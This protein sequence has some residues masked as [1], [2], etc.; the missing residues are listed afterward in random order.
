MYI[1]IPFCR[2]ACSYC[3]FHFS[4]SFFYLDDMIEAIINE[5]AQRKNYLEGA[6]LETIYFGGGTPSVLNKNHLAR[7]MEAIFSNYKISLSREITLEANPDDLTSEYLSDIVRLGFNRLSIGVQSFYQD[8]LKLMNRTHDSE[9]AKR[10]IHASRDAGL[11]NLNVDLI[12]GFPGLTMKKWDYNICKIIELDVEHLSAY[13]ITYEPGTRLYYLKR[14]SKLQEAKESASI[15][16]YKLLKSKMQD[17]GYIHY[18]I[19]NFA[20]EGYYSK[21]NVAYWTGQSYLGIGPSAHSFNGFSRQWNIS[22]NMSYILG[23]KKERD[24]SVEEMINDKTKYHELVMTNLRTMWGV[25]LQ[26]IE[27]SFDNKIV[28]HFNSVANRF[29]ESGDLRMSEGRICLTDKGM[30]IAD[31]ITKEMFLE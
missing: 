26:H 27:N 14:K 15:E 8:D 19:S 9:Q 2:N 5:I 23:V 3:D 12:Y 20:K 13:H 6:I 16:Q 1:H 30:L 22:K 17:Q 4:V 25:D 10:C 11:T 24:F 18:E 7:I 28:F 31:Y 21:H 29:F